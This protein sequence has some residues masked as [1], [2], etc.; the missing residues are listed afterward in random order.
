MGAGLSR[1]LLGLVARLCGAQPG[2][3]HLVLVAALQRIGGHSR[4]PRAWVQGGGD[5]DCVLG[6]H[7]VD[8]FDPEGLRPV[9]NSEG[10]GQAVGGNGE[11]GHGP[12]LLVSCW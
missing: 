9:E 8:V 11:E 7:G 6:V 2:R 12:Q 1:G 3:Q 4:Q 5:L 10:S